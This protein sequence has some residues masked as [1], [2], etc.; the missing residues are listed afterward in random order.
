[1][2]I[3]VRKV[4]LMRIA[5]VTAFYP[6]E[7][8]GGSEYQTLLIA[9]GLAELGH[10]VVFLGTDAAK[11]GEFDANN[12]RVMEAQS[13]RSVGWRTHR[14][15]VTESLRRTDPDICY[16]RVFEELATI[17]P[18]CDKAGI[19]VISVSASAKTATPFLRGYHPA[20]TLAYVRSF[21]AFRHLRSFLAI[22]S[23]D[24]HVCN[25]RA[26]KQQMRQWFPRKRINVIYNGSPVPASEEVHRGSSGQVIWVN[27]LK[28]WKRPEVFVELARRLSQY[29]FVMIGKI[30]AGRRYTR[31][32]TTALENAT[33][34]LRYLG[35]LPLARVNTMIADSDLLLY[36]SL[37]VEGFGNSFLPDWFRGVPTLSLSFD[38]DGILQREGVG[39][40][41]MTFEE[42]VADVE[43]LMADEPLRGEMGVRARQYAVG[44]HSAR[45]MVADYERLF[46]GLTAQ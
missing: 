24:V 15:S 34:N 39:R 20:E 40:C 36:T 22:R 45:T 4:D 1:V 46:G 18:W 23:S 2:A 31:Q 14:D 19:P 8:M 33:D 3:P 37:P 25:T 43:E 26:L 28:R 16:V 38:L 7:R 6:G 5:L 17:V 27:N 12:V 32:T 9:E 30:S 35:P 41:A 44:H 10:D 21:E 42:L 29:D 11:E 13:W